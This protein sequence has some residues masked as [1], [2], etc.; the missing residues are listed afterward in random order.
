MGLDREAAKQA[1]FQWPRWKEWWRYS[2]RYAKER[3]R[4]MDAGR[5]RSLNERD[6]SR[7][8]RILTL[9]RDSAMATTANNAAVATGV[10]HR[11]HINA[12]PFR[13]AP[14]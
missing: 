10:S 5:L 13:A 8:A 14:Q 6:P 1:L 3:L 4:E 2:V 9:Y 12:S 11:G 7:H